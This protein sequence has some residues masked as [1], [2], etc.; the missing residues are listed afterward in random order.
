M[1][2]PFPSRGTWWARAHGPWR[3]QWGALFAHLQGVVPTDW[4]VIVAAD[5]G[6]WAR[7]LFTRITALGWH[8]FLRITRKGQYRPDDSAT[9]RPLTDAVTTGGPP[10]S[11]RVTCFASKQRQIACT[12]LARWDVGYCD[13]WLVLTDL[14][15]TVADVAWYR[16]RAWIECSYKDMKRGAGTGSRP[17]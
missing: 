3:P 11:G 6:L 16:L 4:T 9:Y 5:R 2:A 10:W 14:P 7:W 12:L 1:G 13:P 8:P 17:R 15:P